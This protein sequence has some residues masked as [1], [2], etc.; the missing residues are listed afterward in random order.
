VQATIDE[1]RRTFSMCGATPKVLPWPECSDA[2]A[3]ATRL[4]GLPLDDI[5][6][7]VRTD[8]NGIS[9]CTHLND[10]LRSL[11]DVPALLAKMPP[12]PQHNPQQSAVTDPKEPT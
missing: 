4:V 11:G 6:Q 3:S 8:L 1:H 5:R 9:T 12:P 2:G 10:L 7:Y